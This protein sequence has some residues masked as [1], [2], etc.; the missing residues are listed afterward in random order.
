ML[1]LSCALVLM[2]GCLYF[3]WFAIGSCFVVLVVWISGFASGFGHLIVLP[4]DLDFVLECLPCCGVW[5]NTDFCVFL[6]FSGLHAGLLVLFCGRF[7]FWSGLRLCWLFRDFRV[8]VL[9][10]P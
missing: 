9:V 4:L 2:F 10:F 1:R 5:F 3:E 8:P 7:V 6:G